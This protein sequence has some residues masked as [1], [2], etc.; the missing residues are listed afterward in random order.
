MD[1]LVRFVVDPFREFRWAPYAAGGISAIYDGREDWRG[2]LV[3]VLGLEGPA[4][5]NVVMA[6]EV[7]FG[8]GA[9][10]GIALRRAMRG[11]R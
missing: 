3:G 5:G 4:Q 11:R 7:G 10:V 8:G 1:G 6:I 2:V 9:R